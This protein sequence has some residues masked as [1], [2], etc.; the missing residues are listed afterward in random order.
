M[1]IRIG[2]G[3]GSANDFEGMVSG[4][5][6]PRAELGLAL[7]RVPRGVCFAGDRG[8]GERLSELGAPRVRQFRDS[9]YLGSPVEIDGTT[10]PG[11]TSLE[12]G[13]TVLTRL[14]TPIEGRLSVPLPNEAMAGQLKMRR[15]IAQG[16]SY[17]DLELYEI[18]SRVMIQ[19]AG[20]EDVL[21]FSASDRETLA[22][23]QNMGMHRSSRLPPGT[24]RIT[25]QAGFYRRSRDEHTMTVVVPP[26]ERIWDATLPLPL[27]SLSYRES[28]AVAAPEALL[29]LR[30]RW[31]TDRRNLETA[32][33]DA[34][35]YHN[36][37]TIHED[38]VVAALAGMRADAN[39]PDAITTSFCR[40][41]RVDPLD[42]LLLS[43]GGETEWMRVLPD[44]EIH[45]VLPTPAFRIGIISAV[46]PLERPVIEL[47]Q[48]LT[49]F[50]PLIPL[51]WYE[52]G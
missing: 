51:D 12:F 18:R 41:F 23:P 31:A 22:G 46:T 30:T 48:H 3:R 15:G 19:R 6:D 52:R 17:W 33:V 35:T 29:A 7:G 20:G 13:E 1:G 4:V 26:E 24:L 21:E 37:V 34:A 25:L 8:G 27:R 9:G 49:T 39:A 43:M 5:A 45:F 47:L 50:D 32:P 42:G 10:Y 2:R 36:L 14:R 11:A 28:K 38:L 16:T 44:V 40:H